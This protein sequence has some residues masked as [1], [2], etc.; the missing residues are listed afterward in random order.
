MFT[1][2]W[3]KEGF[4]SYLDEWERSVRNREGFTTAQKSIT[5]SEG[6]RTTGV[7]SWLQCLKNQSEAD[8]GFGRGGFQI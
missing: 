6:L 8:V 2:Q 5:D 3:L 4:L 1:F 7:A